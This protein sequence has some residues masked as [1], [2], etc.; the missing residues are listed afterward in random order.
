M[1]KIHKLIFLILGILTL[2][3]TELDPMYTVGVVGIIRTKVKAISVQASSE[4]TTSSATVQ[5]PFSN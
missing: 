3:L 5:F 1:K 4:Y 2:I